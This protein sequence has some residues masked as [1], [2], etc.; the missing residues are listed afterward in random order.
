MR[1]CS[2]LL[3]NYLGIWVEQVPRVRSSTIPSCVTPCLRW[4]ALLN[5][6]VCVLG[7]FRVQGPMFSTHP[8]V[9]TH[10]ITQSGHIL[11][12]AVVFAWRQHETLISGWLCALGTSHI[13]YRVWMRTHPA[14]ILP[15]PPA[16]PWPGW[17]GLGTKDSGWEHVPSA[18]TNRLWSRLQRFGF[19][20]APGGDVCWTW[21]HA[22]QTSWWQLRGWK[23]VFIALCDRWT[24][25]PLQKILYGAQVL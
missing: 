20:L 5:K 2:M 19:G 21:K 8:S 9:D 6:H 23:I 13:D 15:S 24:S 14:R 1:Q 18:A 17:E 11:S 7:L 22:T 12:P 4:S 10:S 16:I 3:E 25:E